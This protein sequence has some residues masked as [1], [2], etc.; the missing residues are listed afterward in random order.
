MARGG[1]AR[2]ACCQ[3][4]YI[5][6]AH[7]SST[8]DALSEWRRRKEKAGW[9]EKAISWLIVYGRRFAEKCLVAAQARAE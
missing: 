9:A 2:C 4:R 8:Y 7:I 6:N 5:F 3:Y 1:G